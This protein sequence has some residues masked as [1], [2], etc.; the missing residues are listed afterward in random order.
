MKNEEAIRRA[1]DL[2]L[3]GIEGVPAIADFEVELNSDMDGLPAA[4]IKIVLEDRAEGDYQW[5]EVRPIEEA[6]R[7]RILEDV[8]ERYPYVSFEL[9]SEQLQAAE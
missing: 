8:P 1:V 6:I 7:A 4:Y 9:K 3:D 5:T 2:A